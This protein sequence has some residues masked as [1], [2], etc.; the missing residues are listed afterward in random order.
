MREE[1][2]ER[3]LEH[4]LR[5][6]RGD[7]DHRID[8]RHQ[9][10]GRAAEARHD[11]HL[12]GLR[13]VRE[14]HPARH[15]HFRRRAAHAELANVHHAVIDGGSGLDV[16]EAEA[17]REDVAE[18]ERDAPRQ[19]LQVHER[20][21][22][23]QAGIDLEELAVL[24]VELEIARETRVIDRGRL[25][26][27]AH[28]AVELRLAAQHHARIADPREELAGVRRFQRELELARR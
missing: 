22:L 4:F 8:N 19:R 18:V 12:E 5:E 14:I 20:D 10:R 17:L 26:E 6:R 21:Q 16:I 15:R 7:A 9:R 11:A 1:L 25:A 24:G 2:P 3:V 23:A 28:R 27:P 13:L